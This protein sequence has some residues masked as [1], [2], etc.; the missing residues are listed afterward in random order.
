MTC[1]VLTTPHPLV[2]RGLSPPGA[3]RKSIQ[4]LTREMMLP[5]P[6][7]GEGW[8]EGSL[9][10]NDVPGPDH[11]SPARSS[12]PLPSRGEAEVHSAP[13]PRDDAPSPPT[14]RGLG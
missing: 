11:P 8:G 1:R 7:R 10:T 12:R 14:G 2:P 3:R 5:R 13:D 6:R 9:A 4:H